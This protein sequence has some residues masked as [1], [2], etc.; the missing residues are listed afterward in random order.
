MTESFIELRPGQHITVQVPGAPPGDAYLARVRGVGAMQLRIEP[1]RRDGTRMPLAPGDPVL[2]LVESQQRLFSCESLVV[3]VVEV[4]V[5][6][7]TLR[8][9][10]IA[11]RAERRE[12]YRLPT[13]IRPR[14][15]SITNDD[16]EE[17][18]RLEAVIMDLSGGGL[19]LRSTRPVELGSLIRVIFTLDDD[20]QDLDITL[21]ALSV[22]P[23][24]R[25]PQYR[26]RGSFVRLPR[27][28]QE[29]LIRFIFREQVGRLKRG[30]G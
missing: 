7:V 20:P 17:L 25:T 2:L 21:Q 22:L 3:E 27:Y 1:P 8:R 15:S 26:I 29:R 28:V 30:V 9:P 12:Y 14:Y 11:D 23:E 18:G 16:R 19:Q 13:S 5:E 24:V 6:M 4:P 10:S